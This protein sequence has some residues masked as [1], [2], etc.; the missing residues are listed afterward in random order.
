MIPAETMEEEVIY[1]PTYH[2]S[3]ET[4]N[5]NTV[6]TAQPTENHDK[7]EAK[8]TIAGDQWTLTFG[9]QNETEDSINTQAS[10]GD[11]NRAICQETIPSH[12][13]IQAP[14]VPGEQP[15]T[16]HTARKWTR[17]Q[18]AQKARNKRKTIEKWGWA[19]KLIKILSLKRHA[20]NQGKLSKTIK[21]QST[22]H[23]RLKTT[24]TIWN[25]QSLSP[26]LVKPQATRKTHGEMS[27]TNRHGA[28][29][30]SHSLTIH[31]GQ[32]TTKSTSDWHENKQSP[33]DTLHPQNFQKITS[34]QALL[35]ES[36]Q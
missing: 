22:N 29:T 18:P 9:G 17:E 11:Y 13:Q 7:T 1:R 30:P 31:P 21:R 16:L 27:T 32:K 25:S 36:R 6:S 34:F 23:T 26:P 5:S 19:T 33:A 12:C 14:P 2:M 28:W 35:S 20:A 4:S 24:K 10:F 8:T 3:Q 15:R